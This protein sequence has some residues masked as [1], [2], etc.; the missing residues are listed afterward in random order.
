MDSELLLN[1]EKLI[2][3]IN[4]K[5]GTKLNMLIGV[6][7]FI[8]EVLHAVDTRLDT[9]NFK[10]IDTIEAFGNRIVKASGYSTNIELVNI[11]TKIGGNGPN[12]AVALLE[13]GVDVTY[14]GSI[15]DN[16]EVHPVFKPMTDRCKEVFSICD[17][18]HSDALEFLDGKLML[19]K[20]TT[21]NK[22][23]WENFKNIMGGAERIAEII[24]ESNLFGMENWTMVPHMNELWEGLINE[25]FPLL[26]DYKEDEKPYA[27][28]DLCDPEKRTKES[29]VY[30]MN[31]ITKFENKFRAILGLNEK[32]LYEIAKAFD[33]NVDDSWTKEESYRNVSKAVYDKLNIYSLV[34][35]PTKEAFTWIGDK[36]SKVSG[37]FCAK[38]VLT[39]GAGDNFNGGF[40]F[41]QSL[42]L[43]ATSSLLL[44]V[45]TSGFYVRNAKSPT[46]D[47]VLGFLEDWTK[48]KLQ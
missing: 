44:G 16:N 39:T 15:G 10:K 29:I 25:V 12:I 42:G 18:G 48:G 24:K 21:L 17:P 32:E 31:L 46:V 26:P 23:N 41:G 22:I 33:I 14:V 4:E 20:I 11:Q 45:A 28:F 47:E 13:Y 43:D 8:D 3:E 40:C 30:A 34:I 5:K 19:G 36:Y 1:I 38:P 35:H 2:K 6:D 37:P 7:G 27:F 9:D